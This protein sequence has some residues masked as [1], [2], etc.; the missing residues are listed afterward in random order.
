MSMPGRQEQGFTL[1]ETMMALVVF[2]LLLA[3]LGPIYLAAQGSQSDTQSVLNADNAVRPALQLL[4]TQINSAN[5]L[6]NPAEE[7][8]AAGSGIGPGFSLRMQT[9]AYGHQVC[10][11]WRVANGR[12][13]ERT[14]PPTWQSG[15][16]APGWIVQATGIVNTSSQPPFSLGSSSSY[17][18]NLVKLAFEVSGS[19][20]GSSAAAGTTN[21]AAT[22]PVLQVATAASAQGVLGT[23]AADNPCQAIPPT[24]GT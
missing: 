1:V 15:Q 3:M 18:Q 12:L 16:S 2:A 10:A 14:W 4:V 11:Q 20:P 5:V 13:E 19:S 9:D 23:G 6:Y 8:S 7:G 24:G 17:A 21:P 22:A